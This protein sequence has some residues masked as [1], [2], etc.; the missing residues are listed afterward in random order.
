MPATA[1]DALQTDL[2]LAEDPNHSARRPMHATAQ[3]VP[4]T[5]LILVEAPN[6]STGNRHLL[7]VPVAVWRYYSTGSRQR[8]IPVAV[9]QLG[10]QY[11]VM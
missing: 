2:I 8:L 5:G 4:Q 1:H 11:P 10:I 9:W 6:H 3:D 7:T